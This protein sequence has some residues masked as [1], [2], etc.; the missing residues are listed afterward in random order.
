MCA[1]SM[2][3]VSKI[4]SQIVQS[5]YRIVHHLLSGV[6]II[7]PCSKATWNTEHGT[8]NMEH[9]SAITDSASPA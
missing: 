1:L 5:K 9:D 4:K 7:S 2:D 6:V 3:D 8:W